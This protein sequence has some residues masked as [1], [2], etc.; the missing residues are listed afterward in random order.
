M[1]SGKGQFVCGS[2]T[3]DAQKQLKSWEVNF[4]Y[5][6]DGEKK[7]ALVKL[8]LCPACSDMLNYQ[9]MQKQKKEAKKEEKR[10]E[11]RKNADREEASGD[12][13]DETDRAK[14]RKLDVGQMQENSICIQGEK[15]EE[16]NA[17]SVWS[18]MEEKR[19]QDTKSLDEEFEEFFSDLIQ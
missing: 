9:K 2:L 18:E 19:K 16:I 8:R 11:K 4:G 10:K 3:C 14:S 15:E 6:E 5:V 12:E 7:N 17:A 1:I 13:A